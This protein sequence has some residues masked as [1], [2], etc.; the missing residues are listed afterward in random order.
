MFWCV[1]V[2]VC[3]KGA[4]LCWD[5]GPPM[6]SRY[7]KYFPE[8]TVQTTLL[9]QTHETRLQGKNIQKEWPRKGS[10]RSAILAVR[11]LASTLFDLWN[12]QA[13]ISP[14]WCFLFNMLRL[15]GLSLQYQQKAERLRRRKQ[16]LWWILSWSR[17]YRAQQH[18]WS[19]PS[20]S[21]RQ[22]SGWSWSANGVFAQGRAT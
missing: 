6:V 2:S 5:A 10:K 20:G 19:L 1:T 9:N 13:W 7:F 22:I 3:K 18:H 8:G 11:I 14:S 15:A 4:I 17:S 16:V 21:A 12:D